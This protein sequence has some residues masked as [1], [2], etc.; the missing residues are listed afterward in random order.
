M[1][2]YELDLEPQISEVPRLIEWVEA[3][4]AADAVADEVRFNMTLVLEEAV[5][6]VVKHAFAELPAPHLVRVR[7]EITAENVAAVV[8]DNGRPFD[9]TGAPDA[10]VALPLEDRLPGGLGIHLMRNMTDR[11]D[12]RRSDGTNVLRLEKAR[13]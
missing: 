1:A 5:T 6:N 7:L 10:D 11:L 12:Y 8:T 13:T 2:A 3:C 9:P 4:C